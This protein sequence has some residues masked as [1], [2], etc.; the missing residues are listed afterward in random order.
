MA[1]KVRVNLSIDKNIWENTKK[2]L[3]DQGISVSSFTESIY[4]MSLKVA[5]LPPADLEE[6]KQRANQL[7]KSRGI[8]QPT[9]S[10]KGHAIMVVM[11]GMLAQQIEIIGPLLRPSRQP[12]DDDQ[13]ETPSPG[14]RRE[15]SDAASPSAGQ[16]DE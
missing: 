16:G 5:G 6:Y 3:Q 1:E 14:G 8:E 15:S 10:Q 13:T 12:Q 9:D 2:A 7:L 4:L 11:A